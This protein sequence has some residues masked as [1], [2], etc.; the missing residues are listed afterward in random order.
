MDV[1]AAFQGITTPTP[2]LYSQIS[3]LGWEVTKVSW[4]AKAKAYL[5]EGRNGHGER[6]L[7]SGPNDKTALANLLVA[8]MRH[9][10]MRTAA[11]WKLGMWKTM[12]TD[13]LKDIAEAYS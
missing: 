7:K 2:E 8:A 13:Q 1:T 5:A 10:H 3:N 9:T 6:L 4:D 11:Q 12:F